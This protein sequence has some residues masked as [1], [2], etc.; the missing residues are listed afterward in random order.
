MA[1]PTDYTPEICD[2]VLGYLT[3]L[4]SSEGTKLPQIAGV[5][6]WLG[7]SRSTLY[8]WAKEHPEFSDILEYVS[9]KQEIALVDRGLSGEFNASITKLM[10]TKHGYRDEALNEVRLPKPIDDLLKDDGIQEDKGT[11]EEN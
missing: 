5:A 9:T 4:A 6:D 11:D 3:D 7:V 8:L 1:R 2:R 10:L